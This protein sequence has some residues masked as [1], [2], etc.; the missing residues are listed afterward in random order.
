MNL[1]YGSF[2]I[3]DA[4]I[5]LELQAFG[6]GG[7]GG[8]LDDW[9]SLLPSPDCLQDPLL[10]SSAPTSF[11]CWSAGQN[12]THYGFPPPT[13]NSMAWITPNTCSIQPPLYPPSSSSFD[14]STPPN[15]TYLLRPS[16][17]PHQQPSKPPTLPISPVTTSAP[18]P[19]SFS[20]TSAED[21]TT[22]PR[23]LA[24][25]FGRLASRTAY[26]A[27]AGSPDPDPSL[28]AQPPRSPT[29]LY[30][31]QW[32]RGERASRAGCREDDEDDEDD[33]DDGDDDEDE[34]G[35]GDFA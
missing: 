15:H 25:L 3:G 21:P 10:S 19:T 27:H 16:F 13:F 11:T 20:A 12:D 31:A 28:H 4:W 26:P 29:D 9:S 7:G 5:D 2:D 1:P 8:E 17:N 33:D 14:L 34:D 32:V 35:E 23:L 22:G 24:K 18:P 30:T 6:G